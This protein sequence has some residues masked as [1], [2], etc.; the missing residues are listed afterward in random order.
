[1]A[2]NRKRPAVCNRRAFNFD[3]QQMYIATEREVVQLPI[4]AG[5]ATRS[6]FIRPGQ[7]QNRA[8]RRALD[9]AQSLYI[10]LDGDSFDRGQPGALP[11]DFDEATLRWALRRANFMCLWGGG[12]PLDY[13][14]FEA[15]LR[16]AIEDG[17]VLVALLRSD[18][19]GPW[20]DFVGPEM[21]RRGLQSL[22]V[23]ERH[24][25]DRLGIRVAA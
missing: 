19:V 6:I 17:C 21:Q 25:L 23:G 7:P 2:K 9:K 1:M 8:S 15:A 22:T 4:S 10:L 18:R 3:L 24:D 14:P 20:L 13:K 11:S 16:P 5:Y 12:A